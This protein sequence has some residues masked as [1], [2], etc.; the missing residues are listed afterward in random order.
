MGLCFAHDLS[1]SCDTQWR[2]WH[3]SMPCLYAAVFCNILS[4]QTVHG[5]V[6]PVMWNPCRGLLGPMSCKD[7]DGMCM[8]AQDCSPHGSQAVPAIS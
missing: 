4:Q 2:P 1:K 5:K 6:A 8:H 7:T 3:T